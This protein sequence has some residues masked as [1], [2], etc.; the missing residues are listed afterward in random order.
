MVVG[1]GQAYTNAQ[2]LSRHLRSLGYDFFHIDSSYAYSLGEY[3]S[4]NAAMFPRGMR[5]LGG[6][7]AA[8]GLKLAVWVAPFEVGVHSRIFQHH[9]DWLVRNARGQPIEFPAIE[10][11]QARSCI[12]DTRQP[13]A[14]AY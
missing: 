6:D 3:T 8:L 10:E 11:V 13:G 12:L 7:I 4:P 5:R 14:Q 2:W 9:K 1:E